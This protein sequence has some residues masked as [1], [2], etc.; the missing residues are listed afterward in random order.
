[1][2]AL[3]NAWWPVTGPAVLVVVLGKCVR[4]LRQNLTS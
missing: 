4:Q 2:I 3:F 1:M